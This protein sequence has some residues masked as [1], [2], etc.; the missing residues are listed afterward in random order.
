MARRCATVIPQVTTCRGSCSNPSA[1]ERTG[2][3]PRLQRIQR[4]AHHFGS[5]S[6]LVLMPRLKQVLSKRSKSERRAERRSLGALRSKV[7]SRKTDSRYLEHVSRFLQFLER[8]TMENHILERS[9]LLIWRCQLS[10]SICGK[11]VIPRVEPVM[12]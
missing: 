2:R 10:L 1:R 4:M 11:K 7:V 8:R 3:A 9:L 5:R 12:H 6:V